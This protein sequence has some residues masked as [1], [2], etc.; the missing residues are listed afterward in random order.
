MPLALGASSLGRVG[1]DPGEEIPD[2]LA[3]FDQAIRAATDVAR[4]VH[5]YFEALVASGFSE[6]Q[7]LVLTAAWQ[8]QL[9]ASGQGG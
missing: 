2:P 8:T 6:P 1:D 3:A 7:A 9:I 4:L 5:N